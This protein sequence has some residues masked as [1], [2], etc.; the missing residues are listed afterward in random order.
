MRQFP[1]V[2][3][4]HRSGNWTYFRR[5]PLSAQAFTGRT[6][7]ERSLKTTDRKK[8]FDPWTVANSEFEAIVG[9]ALAPSVPESPAEQP[10]ASQLGPLATVPRWN[11]NL[12][13]TRQVLELRIELVQ[14]AIRDWGEKQRYDRAQRLL[15]DPTYRED[16][17]QFS[18]EC[19]AVGACG[20]ERDW[21]I[22]SPLLLALTTGILNEAG[23]SVPLWH[24]SLYAIER[25]VETEL[26]TVLE[27][28][29]RWRQFEYSDIPTSPPRVTGNLELA[30]NGQ[31][32]LPLDEIINRYVEV[33]RKPLKTASKLRLVC[34][35]IY[36]LAGAPIGVNKVSK[37]LLIELQTVALKIPSRPSRAEKAMSIR[38]L[39]ARLIDSAEGRP[40]LTPQ[41]IKSWFNLLGG[42]L[43]WA[44]SA[45]LLP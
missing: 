11:G 23:I 17:A 35:Y 21:L 41:A 12:D 25:M 30:P 32:F 45:D 37:D 44:V 27:A 43:N 19:A 6:F 40:L 34:R 39:A 15:N 5:F 18:A 31:R 3:R 13:T 24:G 4:N 28:E 1:H 8:I 29:A 33:T 38:E 20:K 14:E 9:R 22:H 42:C 2:K 36:D 7:F 26:R 16:E 10:P